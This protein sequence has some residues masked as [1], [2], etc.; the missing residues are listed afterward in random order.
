MKTTPKVARLFR[1]ISGINARSCVLQPVKLKSFANEKQLSV[2][3]HSIRTSVP[4]NRS[5]YIT[6]IFFSGQHNDAR[7]NLALGLT[8][9]RHGASVANH[10]EVLSILKKKGTSIYRSM[11]K[12]DGSCFTFNK[13]SMKIDN[14]QILRMK[15]YSVSD[16][17][18][19]EK[20]PSRRT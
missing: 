10:V 1:K 14:N 3:I 8:A 4:F 2:K 5:L 20:N 19:L 16:T 11:L 9:V 7:M 13:N 6:R 15:Y 12:T 17:G 18:I